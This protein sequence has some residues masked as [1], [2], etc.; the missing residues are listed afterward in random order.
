MRSYEDW[1]G[2]LHALC[3]QSVAGDVLSL[4]ASGG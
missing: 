1:R 4:P 2:T 3:Q